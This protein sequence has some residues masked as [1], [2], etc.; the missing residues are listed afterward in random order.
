V[1]QKLVELGYSWILENH[2]TPQGHAIAYL[3]MRKFDP[4]AGNNADNIR[5]IVW[6]F[7]RLMD[8]LPLRAWRQ[9]TMYIEDLAGVSMKNM[10][11]NKDQKEL[12]DAIINAFPLRIA[13]ILI[14]NPGWIFRVLIRIAKF[15][16][17][18]KIVKRVEVVDTK[19]LLEKVGAAAVTTEFGGELKF[20]YEQWLQQVRKEE[21][22][23]DEKEAKESGKDSKDHSSGSGSQDKKSDA[24]ASTQNAQT[25]GSASVQGSGS[26]TSISGGQSGTKSVDVSD[27]SLKL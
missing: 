1:N 12:T 27:V 20:S 4:K 15:F 2:F 22:E 11:S 23:L 24:P 6:F 18:S 7:E 3:I 10:G 26:K 19:Q 25:S 17:K 16:M 21:A 14:L 8:R 5:F 13:G 9:G